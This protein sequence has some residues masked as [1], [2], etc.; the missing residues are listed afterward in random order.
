MIGMSR[1]NNVDGCQHK[2]KVGVV[3]V[4]LCCAASDAEFERLP[5]EGF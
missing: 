4:G 1:L 5:S 2:Q 3:Q